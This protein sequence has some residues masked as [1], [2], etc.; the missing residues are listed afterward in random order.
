[1]HCVYNKYYAF[2]YVFDRMAVLNELPVAAPFGCPCRACCLTEQ[3]PFLVADDGTD[4]EAA[5]SI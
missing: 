4:D 3:I 2:R 5:S 1:M